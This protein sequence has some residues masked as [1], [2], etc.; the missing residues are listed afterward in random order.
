MRSAFN[1]IALSRKPEPLT[2]A[3]RLELTTREDDG[4]DVDEGTRAGG[5]VHALELEG[6]VPDQ[7]PMA[8]PEGSTAVGTIRNRIGM[9]IRS[10]GAFF[11][12]A[13]IR[14]TL[15]I[16]ERPEVSALAASL[17]KLGSVSIGRAIMHLTP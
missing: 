16:F 14:S 9:R 13:R 4:V 5:A 11:S 12:I 6:L 1:T 8:V 2:A 15:L 7:D 3:A 17:R 10:Q